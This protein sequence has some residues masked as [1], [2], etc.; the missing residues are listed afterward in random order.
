MRC[1]LSRVPF[2]TT[3]VFACVLAFIMI[4]AAGCSGSGSQGD[5]TTTDVVS[6]PA[7]GQTLPMY[8]GSASKPPTDEAIQ[9][10]KQKTGITVEVNYGGSGTV[11]SQMKL[12]QEG[13]LYFPG[14]S[15]YMEKAKHD[16]DV[17]S[18]TEARVA[19]LV[20]AINVQAGNPKNI[21]GLADLVRSD[22]DVAIANPASVCVGLYAVEI[23]ERAL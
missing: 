16:G 15:D 4:V 1:V 6:Q 5:P 21:Q 12:A 22:V 17:I 7:G 18:A 19:Y 23:I 2:R 10:F 14:S 3:T 11:L 13:D 9:Q 20:P 8:A